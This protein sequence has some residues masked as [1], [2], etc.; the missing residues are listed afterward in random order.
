MAEVNVGDSPEGLDP[1]ARMERA[2][3]EL[4][5]CEGPAAV[6]HRRVAEAAGVPRGSANYFFPKRDQL[7]AAAV[8]AAEAHRLASARAYVDAIVPGERETLEVAR[9]LIRAWYAPHIDA[10]VVRARLMP[11]IDALH[12]PELRRIVT[13]YRPRLLSVLEDVLERCG[14]TGVDVDLIALVLDGALLYENQ[15]GGG[16]DVHAA[17]DI[18]S[19]LLRMLPQG[20]SARADRAEQPGARL[21]KA[22]S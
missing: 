17:V 21:Q 20:S 19:R 5:I 6:T 18:V 22:W 7:F 10:D 13:D 11:M 4:L 3:A 16:D 9:L 12:D 2:A 8:S 1:R 14:Y 15:A